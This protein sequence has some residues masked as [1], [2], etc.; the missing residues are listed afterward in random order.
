MQTSHSNDNNGNSSKKTYSWEL[1]IRRLAQIIWIKDEHHEL[2][3]LRARINFETYQFSCE[4]FYIIGI[5]NWRPNARTSISWTYTEHH[6]TYAKNKNF[7]I[8]IHVLSTFHCIFN[9]YRKTGNSIWNATIFMCSYIGN[10]FYLHSFSW[11]ILCDLQHTDFL[12]TDDDFTGIFVYFFCLYMVMGFL[13]YVPFSF[14]T[15]PCH[16][17]PHSIPCI[18]ILMLF[19]LTFVHVCRFFYARFVCWLSFRRRLRGATYIW[20]GMKNATFSQL[21]FKQ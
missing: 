4:S 13:Q 12:L 11:I 8:A 14:Y 7:S 10:L 19:Y 16:A 21:V 3:C 20:N 18:Y 2:W 6:K 5:Y 17:M 15:I 9:S 1:I